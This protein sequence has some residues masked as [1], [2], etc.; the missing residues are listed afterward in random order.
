[1]KY[2]VSAWIEDR[3]VKTEIK[4]SRNAKTRTLF[5]KC[6]N[7]IGQELIKEGVLAE[8]A[9]YGYELPNIWTNGY[10]GAAWFNKPF[11][12]VS[13]QEETGAWLAR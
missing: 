11:I 13:I 7:A 9:T 12:D 2:I 8:S 1:M 3:E 4:V 5:Q 10:L 6:M